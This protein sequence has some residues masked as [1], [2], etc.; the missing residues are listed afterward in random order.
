[1]RHE[2][3]T[4]TAIACLSLF[5]LAACGD[6]APAGPDGS[7]SVNVRMTDA[8]GDVEAA[9]V[10]VAEVYAEGP[11]GRVQ[12]A[13]SSDG[14]IELTQLDG[15]STVTLA[16][17]TQVEAN[18]YSEVFVVVDEAAVETRDGRVLATS[19]SLSL[20]GASASVS[21]SIGCGSC[22][23]EA[24]VAVGMA[25]GEF[26]VASGSST[27]LLLDFDVARSFQSETSLTGSATWSVEPVIVASEDDE[28]DETGSLAGTVA[29]SSG[30]AGTFPLE[31]GGRT[32]SEADFLDRLFLVHAT[33]ETT[34]DGQGGPY[35]RST[36]ASTEG[37]FRIE[38]LPPDD[39]Q[40]GY[41]ETRVFQNGDTLHVSAQPTREVVT[42]EANA[43]ADVSYT[44]DAAFCSTAG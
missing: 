13:G 30:Q 21:G 14:M 11:D 38:A 15:G 40:M 1:M 9:W 31:C 8:S 10:S 27:T 2:R 33:A 23:G 39:Y 25:G 43:T 22:G 20:P 7:G 26:T 4:T 35:S 24:G 3:W 18:S 44:V 32:I 5:A 28:E 6:D 17:G 16:S 12:L 34:S 37:E 41:E 19:A 36:T 29:V 42:V